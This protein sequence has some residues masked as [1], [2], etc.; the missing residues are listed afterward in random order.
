MR[1]ITNPLQACL[2]VLIR[3]N[4]VFARLATANNW[5]WVPFVLLVV[6]SILPAYAY[7]C[8]IGIRS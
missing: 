2:D 6:I 4:P 7:F 5:S 1:E 8:W 3:P